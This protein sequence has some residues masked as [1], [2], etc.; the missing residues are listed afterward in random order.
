LR[1]R[2]GT[3]AVIFVPGAIIF[4]LAIVVALLMG[5]TIVWIV[6][7]FVGA[8]I[9]A[10]E[11]P[12]AIWWFLLRRIAKRSEEAQVEVRGPALWLAHR[13]RTS[14]LTAGPYGIFT[15]HVLPTA[16]AFALIVLML[17][18]CSRAAFDFAS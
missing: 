14:M 3:A 5:D 15:R 7:F 11:V 9:L 18:A 12:V 13:L 2:Y 4:L 1:G 16:F 10:I 17:I 6:A 8:L